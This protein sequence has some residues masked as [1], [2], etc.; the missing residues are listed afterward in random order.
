MPNSQLVATSL[1]VDQDWDLVADLIEE[2]YRM[3]APK[4]LL[5]VLDAR[6]SAG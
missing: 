6:S 1:E 3:T 5:A 2:A 4:R